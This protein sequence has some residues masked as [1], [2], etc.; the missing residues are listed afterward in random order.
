MTIDELKRESFYQQLSDG[1]QKYVLARCGGKDRL[2]AAKAAWNCSTGASAKAMAYKADQ[3]VN[4][5]WLISRFLG[6]G[7][8]R[9]TPDREEL[10]AYFWDRMQ[11]NN[12]S[13]ADAYRMGLAIA[14]LSAYRTKPTEAK[15]NETRPDDGNEPFS[16]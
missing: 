9:R 8:A 5:N 12:C 3:N 13:D 1:Q 15:P 14:D 4:I 11:K 10:I 2:E 6:V 16:L 7:A